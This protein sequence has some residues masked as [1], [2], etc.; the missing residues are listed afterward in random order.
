MQFQDVL[1]ACFFME[2]INVLRDH[3]GQPVGCFPAGQ[4]VVAGIGNALG[5]FV[6]CHRFLPPVLVSRVGTFQELVVVNRLRCGPNTSRRPEV[7]N[8]TLG[9]DP[10]AGKGHR[11]V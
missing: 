10:R 5:K 4:H 2:P 1:R 11:V 6:V 7:R 8:T 9:A 3:T